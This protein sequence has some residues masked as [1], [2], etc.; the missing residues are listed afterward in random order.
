MLTEG[1][2]YGNLFGGDDPNIAAALNATRCAVVNFG[3]GG[4]YF[5]GAAYHL[6]KEFEQ[7]QVLVDAI[8]EYQPIICTCKE[9]LTF[10]NLLGFDP[11]FSPGSEDNLLKESTCSEEAANLKA[12]AKKANENK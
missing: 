2:K 11:P 12:K 3:E 6:M 8:H 1:I 5:I 4:W 10:E 7:E 9:T